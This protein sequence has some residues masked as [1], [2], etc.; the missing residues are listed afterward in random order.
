MKK[1]FSS[2]ASGLLTILIVVSAYYFSTSVV[3]L[4]DPVLFPDIFKI[5]AAFEKHLP[6]LC[7][8]LV[9]SMGL[10]I[11]GVGMATAVGVLVG[12]ALGISR[13]IRHTFNPLLNVL[14]PIP[15]TLLTPYAIHAFPTFREA[16]IFVIFIGSFWPIL[17]ATMNG[18]MTIDRRILDNAE[19]LEVHGLKKLWRIIIPAASPM[20]LSG[21]ISALRSAFVLLAVAE[22]FGVN[23][24]MG[25]F[26]QYY[27]DFVMFDNVMVG[28]IFMGAVLVTLLWFFE[29]LK[30]RL[31]HWTLNN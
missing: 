16:S 31:L 10:L 20:I 11:P 2:H 26:I 1:I 9:S 24:G 8:G 25:Y 30:K 23:A 21:F 22:M 19:M 7:E 17:N 27:S 5:I 13:R 4:L 15:A 6:T 14:S 3:V 29:K 18:V 12:I 28:F